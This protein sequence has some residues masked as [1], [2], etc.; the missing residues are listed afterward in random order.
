VQS[1]PTPLDIAHLDRTSKLFNSGHPSSPVDE[2]VRLRAVAAGI[3][4]DADQPPPGGWKDLLRVEVQTNRSRLVLVMGTAVLHTAYVGD[5]GQLRTCGNDSSS[6]PLL[7][8]EPDDDFSFVPAPVAGLEG[9]RVSIVSAGPSH[10]VAGTDGA[11]QPQPEPKPPNLP[12]QAQ[13]KPQPKHTHKPQPF[14]C[15]STLTQPQHQPLP[16]HPTPTPTPTQPQ[17][18]LQLRCQRNLNPYSTPTPTTT[19]SHTQPQLHLQLEANSQ[20]QPLP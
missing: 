2:G 3:T 11:P 15:Y 19:P 4:L 8:Y 20:P 17:P 10:T 1:L 16:Y 9:I 7:G 5:D 6:R 13:S 14:P 12:P 18:Q